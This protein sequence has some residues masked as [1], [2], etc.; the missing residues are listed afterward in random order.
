MGHYLNPTA[1]RNAKIVYIFGLSDCNGVNPV[2]TTG[3]AHHYLDKFI[4]SFRG[5]Y[6][7]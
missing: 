2:L 4:S 7:I 5:F 3:P 1:L 6:C